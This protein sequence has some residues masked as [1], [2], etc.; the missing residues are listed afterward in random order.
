MCM[1]MKL[2]DLI[3]SVINIYKSKSVRTDRR[4]S[5][6][7][8]K[9]LND[10]ISYVKRSFDPC[11]D[12][13]IHEMKLTG[14]NAA[15]FLIDNMINKS[16][17]SL[18]ILEPLYKFTYK[19]TPEQC[20]NDIRSRV[21]YLDDI[22]EITTFDELT[23]MIMSGFAVIAVDGCDRMIAAGIQGF[24]SR[25]ISEPE[26]D[27]IQRG[28]KEGFVEPLHTNLSMIRRRMK[29]PHLCSEIIK[30]GTL[31]RTEVCICYLSDIAS[32][33]IVSRLKQR[34]HEVTLE[35]V[36]ASGYLVPFIEDK[37]DISPF[38]TVGITERPDTVC[39]KLT[40]GRIAVLIDGVPDALIVPHLFA[41]Y[42]QT[43]DDYSNRPY[44]AVFTRWLK[45][46]AFFISM[47]LPGIFV[48]LATFDPEMFPTLMLNKIAGSIGATPLSLM[49]E[50]VLIQLVYEVM[51]ESGLRMP[52]PLGYAVS[53]VGGLV[54]G[55][56]AVNAGLIGAPT[57]MV[58]AAAAICSYIIPNLYAPAAMLRLTFTF[59]GGI[60]GIGGVSLLF[61]LV[62]INL[63]SK[64]S[65]GIPF[66]SPITP[67]GTAAARDVF[68]RAGWKTLSDK[69]QKVQNMPGADISGG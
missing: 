20:I 5:V 47:L 31:S 49:A 69:I 53:I 62:F 51:R 32:P 58:A 68:I 10:N 38:C 13:V 63:C 54:I 25:S 66:T 55:D 65:F 26:S 52:Q 6:P 67:F 61:C 42:F 27:V 7:F 23:D 1:V 46:A 24:S 35:T 8:G 21:I 29:N 59:I 57:L 56:T 36:L 9:S 2:Y 16:V 19:G 50:T 64:T 33:T 3:Q 44:F 39:G 18:G 17:L 15:V 30:V 37:G 41:E 48:A 40:E 4:K 28:A 12:L 14:I 60:F 11:A 34:L 43:L 22:A 45:L